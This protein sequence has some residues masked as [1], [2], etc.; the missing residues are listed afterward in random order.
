MGQ[1]DTPSPR[2]SGQGLRCDPQGTHPPARQAPRSRGCR[3]KGG[4]ASMSVPGL[5]AVGRQDTS[6]HQDLPGAAPG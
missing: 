1:E 4:R 5:G 2:P 3:W 6:Q